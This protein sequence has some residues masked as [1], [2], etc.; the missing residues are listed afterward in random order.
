MPAEFDA[1]QLLDRPWFPYLCTESEDWRWET[2]VGDHCKL[3]IVL[4]GRGIMRCGSS[5]YR[6]EPGRFFVLVP[7]QQI[8]ASNEGDSCIRRFAAHF[9]PLRKGRRVE[10][11]RFA[12]EGAFVSE[13]DWLNDKA[14]DIMRRVFTER[15]E[16]EVA[17]VLAD[18][19]HELL[20][21]SAVP[22]GRTLTPGIAAT[23]E[24]IQRDPG[25]RWSSPELAR[26]ARFSRSH[27]DREF[28]RLV[29]ESPRR[30]QMRCRLAASRRLLTQTSMRVGE[31]ADTLQYSDIYSFSRQ[32][33][34][35]YGVSP[36]QYREQNACK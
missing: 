24:L 20:G 18:F 6:L 9:W 35:H 10:S 8:Q 25:V 23:L 5:I 30:Y 29:G 11:L 32:F 33:K 4:A 7:G 21:K 13:I 2:T 36:R 31:I 27:F 28:C 1:V 26:R 17:K 3:W 15:P 22:G 34:E 12:L 14:S 19:L 16:E